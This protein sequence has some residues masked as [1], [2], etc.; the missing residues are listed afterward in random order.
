MKYFR[1]DSPHG[2][3]LLTPSKMTQTSAGQMH[4]TIKGSDPTSY[5]LSSG[6]PWQGR[7]WHHPFISGLCDSDCRLATTLKASPKDPL[8]HQTPLMVRSQGPLQTEPEC[9]RLLW[10]SP[11]NRPSYIPKY[12]KRKSET[13]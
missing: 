9:F 8:H 13:V 4:V 7:S 3:P 10:E 11:L 5:R 2:E 12:T 1:D 6:S